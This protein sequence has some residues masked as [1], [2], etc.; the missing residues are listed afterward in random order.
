MESKDRLR[1]CSGGQ[2]PRNRNSTP[3]ELQEFPKQNHV[4]R[5]RS[6][7]I[8]RLNIARVS[9][10]T[11]GTINNSKKTP[12]DVNFNQVGDLDN[13][14]DLSLKNKNISSK[15]KTGLLARLSSLM[16]DSSSKKK[17][18]TIRKSTNSISNALQQLG[19]EAANLPANNCEAS[20]NDECLKKEKKKESANG[21]ED[22]DS[23]DYELISDNESGGEE[24]LTKNNTK[25]EDTNDMNNVVKGLFSNPFSGV[26]NDHLNTPF[27]GLFQNVILIFFSPSFFVFFLSRNTMMR[28]RIFF[29][30]F[31]RSFFNSI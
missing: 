14:G 8:T 6:E 30:L 12:N 25:I 5:S 16:K 17:V 10:S 18:V 26:A 11:D 19:E 7:E 23:D 31:L 20:V 29:R 24:I 2:H 13:T 27:T 3:Q 4:R 22:N 21:V 15:P 9:K 1:I 28:F